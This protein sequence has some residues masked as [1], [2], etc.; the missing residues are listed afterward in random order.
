MATRKPGGGGPEEGSPEYRWLYGEDQASTPGTQRPPQPDQ[1]RV[2]RTQPRGG[3]ATT[4]PRYAPPSG[5][6]APPGT[7]PGE[8]GRGPRRPRG[9]RPKRR[10]FKVVRLLLLLWLV[11]LVAV[12][13]L[14]W[15]EVD[16]V[17]AF[18]GERM[19][20]QPGTTYLL[21]GSDSRE[22]LTKEQ[23]R[24]LG[25]GNAAGRRTDTIMLLHTGSGPH[26]LTSIPRDSLVEIPGKGTNKINAAYAWGGAP[27]LV[28]TVEKATGVRVDHYVEIGFGGFVDV[29]DAVGGVEICPKAPMKDKDAN[30]DIKAGCQEADGTTALGYARSRKTYKALGD[31]DRAKAQ[32]EVVSAVGAKA[33][34]PWTV[35][36]PKRY[37]DLSMAGAN[38]FTVSEGTGPFAMARFAWAM[39]RL[40]GDAG[41]TCGV[42]IRD[43]AVH[44]DEQRSKEFF[45]YLRANNT[46]ELPKKLCTPSGLPK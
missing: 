35:I 44:W 14:A 2:I 1:T 38:S 30:L 19:V 4:E 45:G 8:G 3:T 29:V 17:D 16:T 26:V 20:W 39:T 6:G 42:P 10:V 41:M 43:L 21:V 40:D 15:R 34:S 33:L 36:N 22:G 28:Q 31:V 24:R 37:Y 23:R 11:F 13:F 25:T 9:G 46:D 12:P 7:P 18:K 5:P 27:L 32:R